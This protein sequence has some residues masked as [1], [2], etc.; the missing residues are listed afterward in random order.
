MYAEPVRTFLPT[1]LLIGCPST[2]VPSTDTAVDTDTTIDTDTDT[3]VDTGE[4][5]TTWPAALVNEV[6]ADNRTFEDDVGG[7]ADWV[8]LYN[9]TD[10]DISLGGYGISD[11]W[12]D[13]MQHRLDD[14]LVIEAGGY[15]L[16]WADGLTDKSPLHLPFRLSDN[17]EAVGLF[18]PDEDPLD[19]QV[20]PPLD[21]DTSYGRIPDG[22]PD[23]A[24]L[25]VGTPGASNRQ[26]TI[27]ELP[28][29]VSGA[30]WRYDDSDSAPADWWDADLDDSGW[31]LGT[32]PLGYGDSQTTQISYGASSSSKNPTA[33]FRHR[34]SV[35]TP[36]DVRSAELGLLCDDGAI[37]Y[38]NGTEIHRRNMPDGA[39][40]ED[41]LAAVTVS[42]ADETSFF[43]TD[44]DKIALREGDNVIAVE[45]HQA[46][47]S[48][49][50]L[51]FDLRFTVEILS[52]AR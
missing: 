37:V 8:E 41:T 49:S 27:E 25:L 16:L 23:W 7:Y 24:E 18:S 3:A 20:F 43:T 40:T 34:F 19:W 26:V 5:A 28:L 33:W 2:T 9:P 36:G 52:E 4:P 1:L 44:F 35:D 17:G 51:S 29:I 50:D 45:V 39:V 42:G 21:R 47:L 31:P 32:S 38:L 6:M 11:D 30:E 13:P 12:T 15:L 14:S 48:S 22:G 10:E 46:S